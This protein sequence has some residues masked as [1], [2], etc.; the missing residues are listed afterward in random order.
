MRSQL[1]RDTDWASMAHGIEVRA[2]LVDSVA[3]GGDRWDAGRGAGL[4]R[5]S[6]LLERAF[7]TAAGGGAAQAEDRFRDAARGLAEPHADAAAPPFAA[8]GAVGARLGAIAC[9]TTTSRR[10]ARPEHP[11]ARHRRL[12]RVRRHCAIQP[13]SV[14][15]V[16]GQRACR[17]GA[18]VAEG[19]ARGFAVAQNR[20]ARAA[21]LAIKLFRARAGAS[22]PARGS[23]WCSAATSSMRRSPR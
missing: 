4:R 14:R 9:S 8:L 20:A 22:R 6:A 10:G 23:I 16:G 18:G 11:R 12:R 7:P 19:R 17:L 15:S 5:Q 13:R 3:A 2:P 1:L 21:A